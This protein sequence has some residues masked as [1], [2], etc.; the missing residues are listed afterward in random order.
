MVITSQNED[1]KLGEKD[2]DMHS[3]EEGRDQRQVQINEIWSESFTSVPLSEAPK[4]AP[5]DPE[6]NHTK[7]NKQRR[8]SKLS[9]LDWLCLFF[10]VPMIL[11]SCGAIATVVVMAILY[12]D[13]PILGATVTITR[14]APGPGSGLDPV[15]EQELM[16]DTTAT[17]AADP[18]T[19]NS[20]CIYAPGLC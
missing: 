12:P 16:A 13:A 4:L 20:T 9:K 7:S 10:V 5:S 18:A 14:G 15:P 2:L 3:R 8:W 1:P 17:A 11:L 6:K 19:G